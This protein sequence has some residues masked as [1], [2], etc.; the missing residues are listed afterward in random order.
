MYKIKPVDMSQINS[1]IHGGKD[2]I[3]AWLLEDIKKFKKD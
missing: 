3:E 2:V 1:L